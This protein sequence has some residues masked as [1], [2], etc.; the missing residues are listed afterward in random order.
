MS[1]CMARE[2]LQGIENLL[3]GSDTLCL[4]VCLISCDFIGGFELSNMD[5]LL[6]YTGSDSCLRVITL[7]CKKKLLPF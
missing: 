5:C 1:G 4:Y 7:V 3:C 6:F 2:D